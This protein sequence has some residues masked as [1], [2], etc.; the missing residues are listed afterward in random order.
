MN[1]WSKDYNE[2]ARLLPPIPFILKN[3][4]YL[5]SHCCTFPSRLREKTNNIPSFK[6]SPTV[7]GFLPNFHYKDCEQNWG[8]SRRLT[9]YTDGFKTQPTSA[10]PQKKNHKPQKTQPTNQH[11]QHQQKKNPNQNQNQTCRLVPIC[12]SS[13]L[14]SSSMF[15][16]WCYLTSICQQKHL[17]EWI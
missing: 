5:E 13:L 12:L 4:Y 3:R 8:F 10:L 2:L 17:F 14:Y 9:L 16:L 15:S 11:Q 1:R 7:W 6:A